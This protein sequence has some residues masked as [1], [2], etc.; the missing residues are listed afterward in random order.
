MKRTLAALVIGLLAAMVVI[1]LYLAGMPFLELMELKSRDALFRLRPAI[2]M[3]ASK[4]VVVAVGERSLDR[5]GRWPWPRTIT[6]RLVEKIM[7]AGAGS[8]GLDLGFFEPDNRLALQAVLQL[9]KAAQ[10][11]KPMDLDQLIARHHPDYRLA[12]A[13]AQHRDKV[14]LGYFFHTDQREVAHLDRKE[15]KARIKA[16]AKFAFPMVRYR[17]P[18]ALEARLPTAV[19]PENNLPLLIKAS[20]WG[21]FFN[22]LPDYDGVVRRIPLVVRCGDELFPSLA[23]VALARLAG[24]PLPALTVT[25]HGLEGV[26]VGGARIPVDEQG[27]LAVNFRGGAATVPVVEAVDVMTGKAPPRAL[28]G[29]AVV[30][31]VS[32]AGVMDHR[33]TPVAALL[34]GGYILAQAMDNILAGDF[35]VKTNWSS[36]WDLAACLVLAL[37]GALLLAW[38]HPVAGGVSVLGL[39]AA[40]AA[41]VYLAF[42]RG[43]LISLVHPL[44]ALALAGAAGVLYRYLVL[45]K[46]KQ[47]IRRAFGQYLS[48]AVI[49]RLTKNPEALE[50]G[51]EKKVLTVVFA[52]IRGFTT[53][54]EVLEPEVLASVLNTFMNRLT[55]EVLDQG[56]VLDKYMGDAIMAFFGAPMEQP[57]HAARACRAAL[58]MIAQV[59]ALKPR[60][61]E[62]KVP[63]LDLGV[64][65][66]T[67]PMVVGNMGSDLRFD[68][69]VIGDSVNLGSRLEGQTKEY[70]VSI[71]VSQSTRAACENGFHFRALDLIRVKGKKEPVAIHQLIGPGDQAAP[72]WLAAAEEAFALY[73]K[74]DF[75]RA[76]GLYG[77][78]LAVAPQDVTAAM[79]RQRCLAYAQSPPPPEW[80]GAM[81]KKT[82]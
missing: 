13:I 43:L 62:M 68:Y 49:E 71:V 18:A 73:L 55:Q 51:G 79:L 45:D 81:T 9:Q 42:T 53:I 39:A 10:A 78:V 72:P 64:G 48:P 41:V 34:P 76:A 70:G 19:A 17:T 65:A 23:L 12:T 3:Q 50:L 56:G 5:A 74:R 24:K 29:K 38:L 66:N 80:D 2:S 75:S 15:I 32:A 82:K 26:E 22:V 47:F 7:A 11:G 1:G 61:E 36:L 4:V 63:S 8:L 57:D 77:Q 16:I 33:P 40:Y 20:R 67:G 37:A 27:R 58:G 52:D 6:A 60:W 46:D 30:L 21:G 59:E 28:Q 31:T 14:C 69:T 25:A 54:S 44:V 35:L